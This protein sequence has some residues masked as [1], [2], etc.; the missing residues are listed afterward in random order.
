LSSSLLTVTVPYTISHALVLSEKDQEAVQYFRTDFAR[1]HHTKNPEYSLI[2]LMFNLARDEPMVMHMVVAIGH[3]EMEFRR[4]QPAASAQQVSSYHYSSALRL[5]ADAIAPPSETTKHLDIILTTLWLMLLYEQQFGDERC[6][7]YLNHLQGVSSLLQSQSGHLLQLPPYKLGAQGN[8]PGALRTIDSSG[9]SKISIYSAR[10]LIWIVLL[11]SAAAT[12]GVG[13]HVNAAILNMLL[14]NPTDSSMRPTD[15]IKAVAR[16]HHYSNSLYRLAWGDAYPQA[17]LIDDVENRNV[18]ALLGHCA[19]LRFL[20]AQLATTYREDPVS[21][22]NQAIEVEYSIDEVGDLFRELME[23]AHELSLETDNSHRLIANLRAIV[24][25]YYAIILD[26]MRLTNFN[27]PMGE[28]QRYALQEIMN[29]CYQDFTHC[30]D[31]PNLRVAWPLFMA[32]LETQ[33]M[34]HQ[35]FILKRFEVFRLYGKNYERAHRF[36]INVIGIQRRDGKR[37]DFRKHMEHMELFVLG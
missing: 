4:P 23:V 31:Q 37:T 28:R 12:S 26:F 9:D 2:S 20:T 33:D 15:P 34:L 25:M 18:Y 13:G 30:G 27:E 5:M 29:L 35:N 11:D 8:I 24:P 17:E 36:L 21:A 14:S 32:A 1:I 7:A 22:A 3:Q 6:R 19:Y 16:L 10:V